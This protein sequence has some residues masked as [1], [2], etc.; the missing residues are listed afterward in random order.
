MKQYILQ[1]IK[2]H[3]K[4]A[5]SLIKKNDMIWKWVLNNCDSNSITDKEKIYTALF[6]EPILCPCGSGKHR[7]IS[8]WTHIF[9]CSAG[10]SAA[11]ASR[12]ETNL[13]KY[14]VTHPSKLKETSIKR[15]ETNIEKYGVDNPFKSIE[16]KHKIKNINKER[17]GVEFISQSA[18][19][20]N[21]I[22]ET[23]IE[24]YGTAH[25]MQNKDYQAFVRRSNLKKYGVEFP[26]Q[27][28]DVKH[29]IKETNIKRY[30]VEFPTQSSE[31]KSKIKETNIKRYGVDNPFKSAEIKNKI[32]ETNI[33]RYGAEFPTQSPEIKNKI[34]ETNIKRYGVE[35]VGQVSYI[36]EV[37]YQTNL[38][39][40]GTKLA[41]Q[42]NIVKEK[43][44]KTNIIRYGG[45]SPAA[46]LDIREK[47]K[48]TMLSRYGVPF[49]LQQHYSTYT[50][51]ILN[52]K[53]KFAELFT[54]LSV[55]EIA[56][57]LGVSKTTILVTHNKYDLKYISAKSSSYEHEIVNWLSTF[58]TSEIKLHDRNICAPKELDIVIPDYKLAIEFDGNYWHSEYGGGKTRDYHFN[59]LKK[60]QEQGIHLITV[61]EDEWL[62]SPNICKSIIKVS[63]G[64][65]LKIYARN[66]V[67]SKINNIELKPFLNENHLQG[68]VGGSHAY[69]LKYNNEIVAAM[70][71]GKPR[72]NKIAQ[73]E[74]LRLAYANDII[75]VGGLNKL[76]KYAINELNAS[77]VISYCDKRWFIGNGYKKLNFNKISSGKP[78]YW[79]TNYIERWHRSNFTK[80]KLIKLS[81][82]TSINPLN[83]DWSK[84]SESQI[85]KNILCLDRIWDCGQ[86][87]WLWKDK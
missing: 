39:K 3:S 41:S 56:N 1:I 84:F 78:T 66:C 81:K 62:H 59:K 85:T 51:E 37:A 20:K 75:I 36:K 69:V 44:L 6:N 21:K 49:A 68:W 83:T 7:H 65:G 16:I 43:K 55:V 46:S 53:E 80:K 32:K 27:N 72:Y 15:K 40:Y 42:S 77:S 64:K 23:N 29:K 61:F 28:L 87:S 8:G 73:W 33:E 48:N 22:K 2:L 30:G 57:L 54:H 74:L 25:P 9:F 52:N 18:E 86:D 76:W 26:I 47:M 45:N 67:L 12:K 50:I 58:I 38:K 34:K 19:I 17:Y 13:I 11:R 31:I 60:C 14:G 10:C 24:K 70:T 35:N 4:H 82:D 5:T 63:L 71:F 79:Y